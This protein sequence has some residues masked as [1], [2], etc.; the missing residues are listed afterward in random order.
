MLN[1]IFIKITRYI[2]LIIIILWSG[3]P[4]F[5]LIISSFKSSKDILVFP[6]EF[7]FKPTFDNYY[8]LFKNWPE[9]FSSLINSIIITLG[10]TFVTLI[11][12]TIAGYVYSRFRN[13]I[14]SL[15]AFYMI[16]IRMLPPI[17]I[18]LPLFPIVNYLKINDT[19]FILILLYSAFFVSLNTWI[20][21]TFIDQIPKELDES[22]I[23]ENANTLQIIF[24]VII[25]LGIKGI[26]AA[27][28]FVL[29]FA[30]NEF[31][32]A[33]IFTTTKAKTAP[34]VISEMIDAEDGIE[35]GV[36]F[37]ASTIQLLPILIF[38]II[39]QKFVVSGLTAGSV[40]M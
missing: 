10:S 17:I 32:F 34:L 6:P 3:F 37:A 33:F 1:R 39:A 5:F 16:A 36:L 18:T 13:T 35:W 26:I 15:S 12:T 14:L 40:K 30:W 27:S 29:I 19:H 9:F 25:P 8:Y 28:T 21:K 22:A 38:V 24:Y 31:L 20:M 11:F 4:V 2:I 7:I 23:T